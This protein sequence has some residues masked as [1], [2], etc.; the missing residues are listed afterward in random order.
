LNT[1]GQTSAIVILSEEQSGRES[2]PKLYLAL[3]TRSC[4]DQDWTRR[5]RTIMNDEEEKV[6]GYTVQIM[7]D[8]RSLGSP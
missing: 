1:L 2:N 3:H 4:L 5:A 6:S 7:I 8:G